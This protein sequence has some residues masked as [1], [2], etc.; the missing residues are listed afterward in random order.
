MGVDWLTCSGLGHLSRS[1]EEHRITG[2]IL[3]EL[4]PSDLEEI[5]IHAV[6]DKKPSSVQHLCCGVR[7]CQHCRLHLHHPH[8]H[9]TVH[10]HKSSAT[11][12]HVHCNWANNPSVHQC[13]TSKRHS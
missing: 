2:D 4:S 10:T 8:H 3:L 6:G 13:L 7:R 11:W 12:G 1:F 5:G 9:H